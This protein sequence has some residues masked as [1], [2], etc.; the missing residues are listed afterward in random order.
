MGV[1]LRTVEKHVKRFPTF[2]EAI[3]LA[4]MEA[5]SAIENALYVAA[6]WGNVV[7]IQV[8]LYNRMPERW[9][10]RRGSL[11]I[12]GKDGA[13]IPIEVVRNIVK[14]ADG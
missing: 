14:D 5:N 8:W 12:E 9:S 6:K 7:A 11:R 10:D 4:E 1:T 3:D 2:A 13:P